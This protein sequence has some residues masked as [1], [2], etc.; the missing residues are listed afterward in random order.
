MTS[1]PER[2][3]PAGRIAAMGIVFAMVLSLA[4][5]PT[6]DAQQMRYTSGQN[7]VPVFEGGSATP[8]AASRWC[9]AT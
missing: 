5:T 4:L 9:S 3:L 1:M 6:A 8:T 7:V 2:A